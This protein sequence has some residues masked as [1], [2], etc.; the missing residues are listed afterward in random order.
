MS[1]L[2][3]A[4]PNISHDI[5]R[6][7]EELVAAGDLIPGQRVNEVHLARRLGV[8]RTPL[9][10]ALSRLTALETLEAVPRRG[11]FVK[12]LTVRE[13]QELYTI[14][15][16]LDPDA[17]EQGGIPDTSQLDKLERINAQIQ[18]ASRPARIISLDDSWHTELIKHCNNRV[19]LSLI[20][21]F[22]ARTRRYELAYFSSTGARETAT[23]EH[24]R[25]VES[26]R[27]GDL[28]GGIRGL[29]ANLTSAS[30][31]IIEWI[32]EHHDKSIPS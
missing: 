7:V 6:S 1:I 31:Q 24:E 30:P 8:S 17:L 15:K 29:R 27:K 12:A 11:F 4:R 26:L 28:R 22:M 16:L 2:L 3:P 32:R 25:I 20:E 14:R 18:R 21:Q 19:M 23:T 9:R 5:V 13:F 10:E